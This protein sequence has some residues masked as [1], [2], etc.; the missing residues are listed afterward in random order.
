MGDERAMPHKIQLT[1]RKHLSMTGVSEVVAFDD[2][3]VVLRTALGVLTVHGQQLQLKML[4]PQGG[5]VAVEGEVAALIYEQPR[6]GGGLRRL[7]R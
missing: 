3:Q 4:S 6:Q 1:D 5:E 7:F 2:T